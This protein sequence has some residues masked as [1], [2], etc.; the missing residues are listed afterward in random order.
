MA[1]VSQNKR[2]LA[3]SFY[4]R[5]YSRTNLALGGEEGHAKSRQMMKLKQ[6]KDNAQL[7]KLKIPLDQPLLLFKDARF[8][9]SSPPVVRWNWQGWGVRAGGPAGRWQRAPSAREQCKRP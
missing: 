4:W 1:Q 9:P 8:S 3:Q 7:L 5:S 2:R 6:N